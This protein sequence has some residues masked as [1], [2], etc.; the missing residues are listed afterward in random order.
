MED[1]ISKIDLF[2]FMR[3]FFSNDGTYEKITKDAKKK[4]I[5]MLLRYLSIQ[6]P[7]H[8]NE[9]NKNHSTEVIDSLHSSFK[10]EGKQPW[11]TYTKTMKFTGVNSNHQ[12]LSKKY[13]KYTINIFCKIHEIEYK[14]LE[15]IYDIE[16]NSVIPLIDKLKEEMEGSTQS[17]KTKKRK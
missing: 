11:W 4:H 9:I 14:S 6:Y 2:P 10:H 15:F 16:P 5:F 12:E 1:V 17:K 8:I 13:D 7:V 3:A